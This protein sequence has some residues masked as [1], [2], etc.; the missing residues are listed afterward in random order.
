[1]ERGGRG[2]DT[3]GTVKARKEGDTLQKK[4][5]GS[6]LLHCRKKCTGVVG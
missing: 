4:V 2:D 1:M 5:K 3:V 6:S